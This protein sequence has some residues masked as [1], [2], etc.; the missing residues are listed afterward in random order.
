MSKGEEALA[1]QL[2]ALKIPFERE[3]KFHPERRWRAD[4]GLPNSVLVE[5][6]GGTWSGGRHTR[7]SGFEKDCEKYAWAVILGY[8]VLRF[9][10]NQVDSG[11]AISLIEKAL[12]NN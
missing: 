8:R 3:V 11:I 7:G 9:T 10:T 1:F 2:T 5:V 4:F 12:K 6:E